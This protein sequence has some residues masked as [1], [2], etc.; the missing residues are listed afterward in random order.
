MSAL[1]SKGAL[2]DLNR[3]VTPEPKAAR[4]HWVGADTPPGE[5]G[6]TQPASPATLEASRAALA[7]ALGGLL[8]REVIDWK[9]VSV[10]AAGDLE[11]MEVDIT[12]A[13]TAEEAAL[14]TPFDS[15]NKRRS[16][17]DIIPEYGLTMV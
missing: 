2:A 16:G 12:R 13:R 6:V 15:P 14:P 5:D 8:G 1:G 3:G 9:V 11:S 10:F 7:A 4:G 17:S